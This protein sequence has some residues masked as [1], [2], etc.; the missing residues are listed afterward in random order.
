MRIW[1]HLAPSLRIALAAFALAALLILCGLV[2]NANAA[3]DYPPRSIT[4]PVTLTNVVCK[5]GC[6]CGLAATVYRG[7]WYSTPRG[8]C[9]WFRPLR[10]GQTV[11][12]T[13]YR[14]R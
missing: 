12:T 4:V 11:T 2:L 1:N 13:L 5:A 6:C 3:S 7:H 10:N 8:Y 9:K 14:V